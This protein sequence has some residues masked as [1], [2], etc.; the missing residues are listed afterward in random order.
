MRQIGKRN[1]ALNRK[2]IEVAREIEKMDSKAARWIAKDAIK[3]LTGE[4][5][6][7]RLEK[8]ERK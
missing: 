4:K 5:V 1:K 3:E 7:E 6:K 8:K 2:A